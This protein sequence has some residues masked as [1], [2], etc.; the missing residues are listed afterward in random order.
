MR[1]TNRDEESVHIR[2]NNMQIRRSIIVS[3]LVIAASLAACQSPATP[4]PGQAAAQPPTL[5][6]QPTAP[7][8][9]TCQFAGKGATITIGGSRLNF[10]CPQAAGNDVGLF[11]DIQLARL[12]TFKPHNR[13]YLSGG[14]ITKERL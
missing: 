4:V 12:C 1:V 6:L 13:G 2:E 7:G 10:T 14:T 8:G 5:Q 9:V 11:G 3:T